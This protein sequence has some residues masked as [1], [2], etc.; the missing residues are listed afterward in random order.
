M[1]SHTPSCSLLGS[2]LVWASL[3]GV[4]ALGGCSLEFAPQL[5]VENGCENSSECAQGDVCI[6]RTALDRGVCATTEVE[7]GTVILEV[8]PTDGKVAYVFAEAVELASDPNGVVVERELRLPATHPVSGR[9][10]APNVEANCKARDGSVPVSVSLLR[11]FEVGPFR[12]EFQTLSTN[13]DASST[14][15][16]SV[17]AG[18][19]DLYVVPTPE[20]LG[21]ECAP[22]AP[23]LRTV[24]V[25]DLGLV[26]DLM[27][28][29]IPLTGTIQIPEGAS[30]DGWTLDVV[31]AKYGKVLS[32][33]F[34]LTNPERGV[35]EVKIGGPKGV[36]YNQAESAILRLTDATGGLTI[37][38]SLAALDFDSDNEVNIDI[39][40]LLA[41]PEETKAR[42]VGPSPEYAN[43]AN[44]QVTIV[45]ESLTGS[46]NQNASFRV[47]AVSDEVGVVSVKLLPGTYTVTVLPL[48]PGLASFSGTWVVGGE[49][50]SDDE[51]PT[52]F[53][54]A[55]ELSNQSVVQGTIEDAFGVELGATAV[56]LV[57]SQAGSA[58]YFQQALGPSNGVSRA[59]A[60]TTDEFGSFAMDTDPGSLDLSVQLDPASGYPW[61]VRPSLVVAPADPDENVRPVQ[62]L[63]SL[64]VE[65]P[66][67]VQGILR[68][69]DGSEISLALVRAYVQ[70]APVSPDSN[71]QPALI[72]IGGTSTGADGRFFLPLP[73]RI[74]VASEP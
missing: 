56:S 49:K 65:A 1:H 53:G 64:T 23:I 12:S 52:G 66:A 72:Q 71:E 73:R 74:T 39:R 10:L 4:V 21:E 63:G 5:E 28:E 2:S 43:I 58:D 22:L 11:R 19:Y 3:V 54:I 50:A 51:T 40:D 42:V 44:A 26:L 67:I 38:W 70:A 69:A 27:D 33:P 15:E 61:L 30:V 41:V 46:V 8:L 68:D 59:S 48:V 20:V 34:A 35:G 7:L 14:F 16:L 36:R 24:D 45:S 31:D 6:T 55:L 47:N 9:F 17:P 29:A 18:S 25:T 57:P 37:H 60:T 62:D 32:E 13:A